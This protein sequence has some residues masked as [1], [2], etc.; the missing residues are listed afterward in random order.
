MK[1]IYTR[2]KHLQMIYYYF[3]NRKNYYI[4]FI[5]DMKDKTNTVGARHKARYFYVSPGV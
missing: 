4:C 5:I 2:F 1:Q 3:Y